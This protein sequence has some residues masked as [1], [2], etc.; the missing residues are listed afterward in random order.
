MFQCL[1]PAFFE[2]GSVSF[3]ET[4]VPWEK[5]SSTLLCP[6]SQRTQFPNRPTLAW[7]HRHVPV[8]QS[9]PSRAVRNRL[10]PAACLPCSSGRAPRHLTTAS[11]V[12]EAF[13]RVVS[14]GAF[15]PIRGELSRHLKYMARAVPRGLRRGYYA[16]V[17]CCGGRALRLL[18]LREQVRALGLGCQD[19]SPIRALGAGQLGSTYRTGAGVAPA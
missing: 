1:I 19:D 18:K 3:G 16:P 7:K 5:M 9:T 4:P 14:G 13:T 15:W 2:R 10:R 17:A 8:Q 12:N 11:L 6:N